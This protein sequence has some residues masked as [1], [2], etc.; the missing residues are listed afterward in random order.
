VEPVHWYLLIYISCGIA[1]FLLLLY[2]F[3]KKQRL[4]KEIMLKKNVVE[5]QK[6]Q[7][8]KNASVAAEIQLQLQASES[9]L[10]AHFPDSF[11]LN[12]PKQKVG[13]DILWLGETDQSLIVATVDCAGHGLEASF[14]TMVAH[15]KLKGI[16]YQEGIESPDAVLDRLN[17]HFAKDFAK[18]REDSQFYSDGMD[19]SICVFNKELST[20]EY[21][22]A[23]SPAVLIKDDKMVEL[24]PNICGIGQIIEQPFSFKSNRYQIDK[25]DAVFLFSDGFADQFGGEEGKKLNKK[26][27]QGILAEAAMLPMQAARVHI[28]QCFN[29][30]RRER[31]QTDDVLVVGIRI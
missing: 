21:A 20:L 25:G 10:L 28:Q 17:A 9:D 8:N 29:D 1:L 2:Y 16:V 3:N 4:A 11:L 6:T 30:W 14:M 27:F 7:L 22:G 23:L 31:D 15:E 13:G 18:E 24:R 12:Q 5:Q 19:V 26:R